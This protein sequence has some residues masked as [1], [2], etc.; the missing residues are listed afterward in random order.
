MVSVDIGKSSVV[1]LGLAVQ[2]E[3]PGSLAAVAAMLWRSGGRPPGS[4]T[5]L[6]RRSEP[7]AI[8]AAVLDGYRG[9]TSRAWWSGTVRGR[10]NQGHGFLS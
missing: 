7:L 3:R 8:E 9:A 1:K 10:G 2:H 6:A 5:S 4:S